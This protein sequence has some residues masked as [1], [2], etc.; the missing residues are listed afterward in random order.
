MEWHVGLFQFKRLSGPIFLL[1]CC[2]TWP[3]NSGVHLV[4]YTLMTVSASGCAF[5]FLLFASV[6]DSAFACYAESSQ[7]ECHQDAESQCSGMEYDSSMAVNSLRNS[8]DDAVQLG[9]D[10]REPTCTNEAPF[11]SRRSSM[12][13]SSDGCLPGMSSHHSSVRNS[14]DGGL[15]PLRSWRG[16]LQNSCDGA[17]PTSASRR[18]SFHNSVDGSGQPSVG[19]DA[20]TLMH[21]LSNLSSAVEA[22]VFDLEGADGQ[23][24]QSGSGSSSS[25]GLQDTFARDLASDDPAGE[26]PVLSPT[27]QFSDFSFKNYGLLAEHNMEALR[28]EFAEAHAER[29]NASS[30]ADE[31]APV[32]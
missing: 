29:A 30:S 7:S 32:Q 23:L 15:P 6:F 11:L 22:E 26:H 17:L 19:A 4:L 25:E 18:D 16:S 5:T 1:A 13:I 31:H 28:A 3:R 9:M 2:Q 14:S 10:G 24:S 12:R 27:N 20:G 21:R 8:M